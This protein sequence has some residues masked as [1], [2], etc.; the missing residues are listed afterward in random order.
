[1]THDAAKLDARE[2]HVRIPSPHRGR[3]LFLRDLTP[4]AE[5]ATERRVVLYVQGGRFAAA[6]GWPAPADHAMRCRRI[7]VIRDYGMHD[8]AEAPQYHPPLDAARPR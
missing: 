7:R 2:Q 4:S 1:M 5:T 8:R 6:D 3:S